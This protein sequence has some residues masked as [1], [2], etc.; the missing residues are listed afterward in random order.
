MIGAYMFENKSP[1]KAESNA[2]KYF[3]ICKRRLDESKA[4]MQ[5][6]AKGGRPKKNKEQPQ[7]THVP[8]KAEQFVRKENGNRS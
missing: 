7:K 2:F 8:E 3:L 5:N 1:T 6:G 4:R